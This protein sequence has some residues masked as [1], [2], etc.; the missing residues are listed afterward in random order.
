M[1][2]LDKI[3]LPKDLKKLTDTEII[4]LAQEIREYIV[5]VVS[6]TGGHLAPNLGVVELTLALH[7]VFSTPKDKIV[8]DVGHQAYVHKI[9]TGRLKEF[10][11][12]REYNGLSG[13][14]KRSESEHDFFDTGHSSN[15][16]S[17][18]LGLAKARDLKKENSNIISVIGDGAMTGGMAFEALNNAGALEKKMIVILNDNKMSISNNVGAM[19]AYLNRVRLD[20]LYTKR[21]EDIEYMLKKFPAIGNKMIKVADRIKD[22]FRYLL[23]PGMLFEELGFKYFGPVDGH[24]YNALKTA[25][26]NAALINKPVLVHVITEK[27]RGY[28]P[29]QMNPDK[30]HGTGSFDVKTGKTRGS[31]TTPSYTKIFGD[32]LVQI[33]KKDFKIVAVTAAMA[34]GTGTSNFAKEFPTRFF[35]V[36]IAEQHAVTMSSA[37]ALEGFKP[38]VAIYDTFLQRAYDQII[39][40]VCMQNSHVIFAIDRAGLVGQDG[41]THHGVFDFAFL[42]HIPNMVIMAPKDENELRHM[43][44]TA[45]SHNGPIAI[46]YPRGNGLGVP[47][48][49]ELKNLP[50]GKSE[51][52]EEGTDLTLLAIGSMVSV[53][54]EVAHKLKDKCGLKCTVINARF[55]KPLDEETIINACKHT[56]GL[57]TLEEHSLQG[58]FGSAVLELL[59]D[60]QIHINTLRIGLEDKFTPHGAVKVLKE[61]YGLQADS[62]VEKVINK[63]KEKNSILNKFAIN[64]SGRK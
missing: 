2:L 48:D 1:S 62:I 43:L 19:S 22:S 24:D 29:A 59:S 61:E 40:D 26:N 23:V 12:L 18:A 56:K 16:I 5:D 13:F 21:K 35:D 36:G 10:K 46:R 50:I 6:T 42:R 7:T 41:P 38:V 28:L 63:F 39:H 15:S 52:I 45:T 9:L 51:I 30:F 49:A 25:L 11:S 54:L 57:V 37:L 53:A 64:F 14:P 60:N 44:F 58:G 32:T 33:A 34:D 47:L 3:D 20:P 8:W 27:G 17:V 55:V 4:E 31:S